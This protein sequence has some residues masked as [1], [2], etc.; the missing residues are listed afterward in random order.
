[1]TPVERA[2][3]A[4]GV[5]SD[6]EL[7]RALGIS[8]SAVVGYHKRDSVPLEQCIKI[9]NQTGVDLNWLILGRGTAPDGTSTI[10][11]DDYIKIPV[12][13]IQA[14]AGNC[15]QNDKEIIID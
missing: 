14:S 6:A 15:Q 10:T 5:D 3:F 8:T 9:A 7:S 13:D 2:K 1:M 11:S 12:Y 4:L